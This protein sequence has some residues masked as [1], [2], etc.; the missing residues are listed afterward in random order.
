MATFNNGGLSCRV[1]TDG[2][3]QASADTKF[4]A[5]CNL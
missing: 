5:R 2:D 3:E 1:Q 4:S